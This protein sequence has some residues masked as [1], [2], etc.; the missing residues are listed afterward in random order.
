MLCRCR[1]CIEGARRHTKT[2]VGI[3]KKCGTAKGQAVRDART[4][5][6][7][8]RHGRHA[9][10]V[11]LRFGLEE[12]LDGSETD[13]CNVAGGGGGGETMVDVDTDEEESCEA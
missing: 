12:V 4:F 2:L 7:R 5:D 8:F 3:V 1:C 6:F 13:V 11:C 10:S 9:A